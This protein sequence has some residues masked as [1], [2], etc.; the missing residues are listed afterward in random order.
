MTTSTATPT[1]PPDLRHTTLLATVFL[2]ASSAVVS[3]HD[4]WIEPSQFEPAPGTH[5][6]LR[7][8]VGEHFRG[9]PV[10]LKPDGVEMTHDEWA[11]DFA[12]CLG[13]WLSGAGVGEM[14]ARGQPVKDDNFLLLFNAHHDTIPFKLPAMGPAGIRQA[15]PAARWRA[16]VDTAPEAVGRHESAEPL[17]TGAQYPLQGRS[18]VLLIQTG[19]P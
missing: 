4:F 16:L 2:V 11:K 8:R 19:A 9:D 3:A 6:T 10:P 14:D 15:G 5:V 12:R 1:I 18:L 13:V 17:E 7:L